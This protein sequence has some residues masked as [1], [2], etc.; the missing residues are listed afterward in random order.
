MCVYW[1]LWAYHAF[2]EY[3]LLTEPQPKKAYLACI[4]SVSA[5]VR[6]ESLDESKKK[7]RGGR[8]KGAKPF[9]LMLDGDSNNI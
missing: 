5:R 6:R 1:S 2:L 9:H 7:A 3:K 8:G 4:A